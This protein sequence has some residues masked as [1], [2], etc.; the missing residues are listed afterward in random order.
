LGA[1]GAPKTENPATELGAPSAPKGKSAEIIA[2]QMGMNGRTINRY[3][4][5][6]YLIE[7]LLTMIDEEQLPMK[8]GV[9]LSYLTEKL[10]EDVLSVIDAENIKLKEEQAILLKGNLTEESDINDVLAILKPEALKTKLS[11]PKLSI[12]VNK[13]IKKIYFPKKMTDGQIDEILTELTK[14]WAEKNNPEYEGYV[15]TTGEE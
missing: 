1:P 14:E 13:N 4:R 15:G 6:T 7:P 11:K 9:Q 12:K 5:L 2:E 10:Q 8:A 3:I